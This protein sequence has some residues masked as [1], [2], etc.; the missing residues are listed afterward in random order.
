MLFIDTDLITIADLQ[1]EDPECAR[2]ASAENPSIDLAQVIDRA[3]GSC[4]D[5]LK[6][7]FQNY[8]GYLTSPGIG[9]NHAAAVMNVYSTAINR[10]RFLLSQVVAIEPDPAKRAV[11]AWL[12]FS[13]LAR[14]YRG[15]YHR[16][17]GDKKADRYEAKMD[18]YN[19]ERENAWRTLRAQGIPVVLSPLACPGAVREMNAGTFA[20]SAVTAGGSGSAEAGTNYQVAI[21][22]V[23]S[24][25]VSPSAKGNAE[26][27]PSAKIT[28]RADSGQVLTVSIAGVNP[29]TSTAPAVGTAEGVYTRMAATGWNVYVG[30]QGKTLY[31]QNA[32]PIALTSS[33]YTLDDAPVLSGNQLQPGQFSDFLFAWQ[34]MLFRS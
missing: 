31:L 34:P 20:D 21:T 28:A 29:P 15:A 5:D 10:P 14:L 26:S 3:I 22:W 19:D 6:A 2:V 24:A 4:G 23:G 25:Y 17:A 18:L 12:E 16:F 13:A 30:L 1:A 27:G 32:T 7:A 9:V 33:T 11:R 8:S